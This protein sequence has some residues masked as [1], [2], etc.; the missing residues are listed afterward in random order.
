ML[1]Y[2]FSFPDPAIYHVI[3]DKLIWMLLH[4][5]LFI[6][7]YKF[8]D[9]KVSLSLLFNSFT[10]FL[11]HTALRIIFNTMKFHQKNKNRIKI[12][13]F[14]PTPGYISGKNNNLKRFMYPHIHWSTIYN[15]QDIKAEEIHVSDFIFETRKKRGL[16]YSSSKN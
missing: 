5:T 1:I 16:Y 11:T 8:C 6:R 13:F 9:N 4:W 10:Y 14:N 7:K 2:F 3:L 12:L 15:S